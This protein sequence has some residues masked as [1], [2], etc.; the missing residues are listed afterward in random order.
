[1]LRRRIQPLVQ[2]TLRE[3][4]RE[5][6]RY[7]KRIALLEEFTPSEAENELYRMVSEYLQRDNLY[8]LPSSQRALMTMSMRKWLASSTYAIAGALRT[9]AN[10]LRRDL[11][12]MPQSV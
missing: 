12:G 8:A 3:D 5:F 11:A 9:T 6:I 4:A 10:R 1:E 7:T 2:R